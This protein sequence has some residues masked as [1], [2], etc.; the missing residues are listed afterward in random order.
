V[1]YAMLLFPALFLI[2]KPDTV[3]YSM[4]MWMGNLSYGMYLFH[5]LIPLIAKSLNYQLIGMMAYLGSLAITVMISFLG[6]L[7]VEQPARRFGRKLA[8]RFN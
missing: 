8:Q 7:L 2:Q 6:Y 5:N 4:C 1:A 3:V